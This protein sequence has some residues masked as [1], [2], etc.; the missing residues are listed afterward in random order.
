MPERK[1]TKQEIKELLY[2]RRYAIPNAV[3]VGNMFCGFLAILYASSD[4]F[5]K[6][7]IAILIAILLDGLDGRVARKLNA[8]SKFGIEFDSF[9]DLVSFGIAPAVLTYHWAFHSL[10]DEIG[11]AVV[12]FFALCS[13]S[14][15]ARFNISAEN[16]K[17]FTGLPTPGAAAFVVAVVNTSKIPE[18]SYV[19]VVV[20]TVMM[21]SVGYLMVS[22][23]D[24]FSIKQFKLSGFRLKGRLML[25]LVIALTWY[26]FT[27]GF[28]VIA[29]GYVLSGP[30]GRIRSTLPAWLGGGVVTKPDRA[31]VVNIS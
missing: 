25:G 24:F 14:R 15:L 8:T 29:A 19:L 16:L 27:M 31:K 13:A 2:R 4:R 17:S 21:L 30:Y 26:N 5:E 18:P 12:F 20:G 23:I 3:T 28:L 11:V 1:L 7:V 10:A 9:S 6:A 22:T